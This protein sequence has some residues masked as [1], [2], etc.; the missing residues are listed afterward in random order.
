MPRDVSDPR[1]YF[2]TQTCH[3]SSSYWD[4]TLTSRFK[5]YIIQ[6]L[7]TG[8]LPGKIDIGKAPEGILEQSNED[9][10][11]LFLATLEASGASKDTIKAYK[12]AISDFLLFI[13][14]KPL[15]EVTLKDVI[16]W[17]NDRLKNGFPQKKTGSKESW[18][19]T[20]HYYTIFLRRFF[21]WLGVNIIIPSV[22]KP[23]R[24]IDVL[25]DTDIE[26]LLDAAERVEEKLVLKLMFD[27]GLRS[28]EIL[29]LTVRDINFDEKTIRVREAKYG[30]ERYVTATTETFEM[31]KAYIKLRGLRPDDRLFNYTYSGL[32]KMLKRLARKAGLDEAKVRPH[33]LRHTFATRALRMGLSLPALQR[34]LGHSDIKTT[35]VYLHLT[36]EDLKKEY[37]SKLDSAVLSTKKCTSCGRIIP[38]DALFCPYCGARQVQENGSA[39]IE[40]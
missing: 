33:V 13:N 28:R 18:L 8:S 36:V 34:I 24:K 3:V 9:I 27:T 37:A 7:P 40:A 21:K 14:G 25:S 39:S 5:T 4:I 17:R 15:K 2:T 10:L 1:G 35:Q 20:L 26:R 32:Y 11:S 12:S 16:A 19:S 29:S 30:R 38:A 31:I 23:P 6:C 22:K